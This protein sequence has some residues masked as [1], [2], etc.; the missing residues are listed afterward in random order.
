MNI[1]SGLKSKAKEFFGNKINAPPT[2][3]VFMKDGRIT[4]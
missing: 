2:K 3:S 1:I 4:P